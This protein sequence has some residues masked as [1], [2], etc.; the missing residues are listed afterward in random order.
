MVK[1]RH[2]RYKSP[3]QTTNLPADI[4]QLQKKSRNLN[5]RVNYYRNKHISLRDTGKNHI[6]F[7]AEDSSE[8]FEPPIR[9]SSPRR[10]SPLPFIAAMETNLKNIIC[11]LEREENYWKRKINNFWRNQ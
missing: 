10:T 6:T 7:S 11:V 1:L 9:S 4:R 2:I 5:K 3:L 8:N